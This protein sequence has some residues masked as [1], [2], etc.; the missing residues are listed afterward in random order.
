MLGPLAR[1]ALIVIVVA[2]P[3]SWAGGARIVFVFQDEP[4]WVSSAAGF[5]AT[6]RVDGLER[7]TKIE[8]GYTYPG[9]TKGRVTA[10]RDN[11]DSAIFH[12]RLPAVLDAGPGEVA[13]FAEAAIGAGTDDRV[14][15]EMRKIPL[16]LEKELDITGDAAIAL[17]Y[18]LGGPEYTVRYV[19]CCNIFGG[20]TIATRVPVNPESTEAGLPE[21]RLSDFV[22]LKPDGLSASTMGMYFDFLLG[23]ERM[24]GATPALYEFDGSKWVEFKSIE[25]DLAA[26]RVSMHCPNGGTFV[27]AAKP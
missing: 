24:K 12:F 19:P 10:E 23:S 27:V 11:A 13:Y 8:V 20:V 3:I 1:L 17:L 4:A 9:G 21:R 25:V 2:G 7:V 5:E 18:P 6:V 26:G 14:R 22:V 15:S 16:A